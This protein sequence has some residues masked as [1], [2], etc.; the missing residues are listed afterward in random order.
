MV[1]STE[2]TIRH[3]YKLDILQINFVLLPETLNAVV[4]R[5]CVGHSTIF[6]LL[7]SLVHLFVFFVAKMLDTVF[8]LRILG[9]CMRDYSRLLALL[10]QRRR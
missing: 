6:H 2:T 1:R 4:H 3:Y 9:L 8:D 7:H 10:Y 5:L